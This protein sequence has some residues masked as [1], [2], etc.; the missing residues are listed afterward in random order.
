M[1]AQVEGETRP[2]GPYCGCHSSIIYG[3][4]RFLN[5]CI[6][7]CKHEHSSVFIIQLGLN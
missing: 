2:F 7:K 5:L 3:C 6:K 1:L 4:W